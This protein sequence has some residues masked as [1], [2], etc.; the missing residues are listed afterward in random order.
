MIAV[1]MCMAPFVTSPTVANSNN[2]NS[3]TNSNNDNSHTKSS[4]SSSS[5]NGSIKKS[6]HN[7]NGNS[8]GNGCCNGH[9]HKK[10]ES[11]SDSDSGSR[12]HHLTDYLS[13]YYDRLTSRLCESNRICAFLA[14]LSALLLSLM[15]TSIYCMLNG[16]KLSTSALFTIFN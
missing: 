5:S 11:D 3:D 10:Q 7:G 4:S 1:L 6:T 16:G 8:N 9:S 2:N 14:T 12:H 15:I 13:Y